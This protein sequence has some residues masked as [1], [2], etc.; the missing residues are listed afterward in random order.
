L[1]CVS[2]SHDFDGILLGRV[3]SRRIGR[4]SMG[5]R[6]SQFRLVARENNMSFI[7]RFLRLPQTSAALCAALLVS[8]GAP[9]L[10]APA[11]LRAS[12]ALTDRTIA[13][14]ESALLV[15]ESA[16]A[17]LAQRLEA[18]RLVSE[19]S[20]RSQAEA[21]VLAKLMTPEENKVLKAYVAARLRPLRKRWLMRQVFPVAAAQTSGGGARTLNLLN[22]TFSIAP[23]GAAVRFVAGKGKSKKVAVECKVLAYG[24]V[25]TEIPGEEAV[26]LANPED[27]YYGGNNYGSN[28]VVVANIGGVAQTIGAMEFTK[29]GTETFA[30]AARI[31]G[32]KVIVSGIA[33]G[34]DDAGCC[35]CHTHQTQL[36]LVKQGATYSLKQI[37]R[38]LTKMAKCPED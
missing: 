8:I 24:D 18:K 32:Q 4:R 10:A 37:S 14:L 12:K 22:S 9:A 28:I 3:E 20:E 38:Q 16:N 31:V 29:Y 27:G 23:K 25:I 21:D 2:I 11:D 13:V 35:P 15:T 6:L 30:D 7:K 33:I 17:T 34:P 5:T 36:T 1:R 26:L 19:D